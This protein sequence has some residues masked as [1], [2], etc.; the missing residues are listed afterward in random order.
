[1]AH[2]A[3]VSRDEWVS[4]RKK[5]LEEEKSFSKARDALAAKRRALPWTKVGKTYEF[6]T[7]Q[8]PKFLGDLFGGRS[9]LIVQHFMFGPDW[10]EG[11][12]SCSF[13]GDNFD[14]TVPHLAARDVAFV[15]VSRAPLQTLLEYH[16]RLDWSFPWVSSLAN[17][18]NFDFDVSFETDREPNQ[19]VY[20]NYKDTAFPA[21]EAP[22]VSVFYK[23]DAGGIYHTYSVYARGLED[24]NGTYRLLDTT[25]KGRDEDALSY[26][27]EWVRRRDQY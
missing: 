1:M 23:D 26:P 19:Q 10:E 24:L 14:R 22:G 18:F 8:G 11:C 17:D 15:A 13:W 6:E 25:P 21:S 5:L 2:N 20:Y 16:E 27:M 9:Q 7:E 12:P 4:A 3:I